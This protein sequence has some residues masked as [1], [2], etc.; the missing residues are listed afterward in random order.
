MDHLQWM[1]AIR[2]RA[3]IADKNIR[4]IHTTPVQQLM[5]CEVK[6]CVFVIN[7]AFFLS[8]NMLYPDKLWNIF[9]GIA[10]SNEKVIWSKSGEKFAKQY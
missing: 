3:Q 5:S 4:I 10:F 1:G 2:M 6:S 8:L 7:Q 9:H